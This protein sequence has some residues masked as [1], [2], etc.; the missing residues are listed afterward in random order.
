MR[1]LILV[2]SAAILILLLLLTS[3]TVSQI[4]SN[5]EEESNG[6]LKLTHEQDVKISK[7]I[8]EYNLL[9]NENLT[10]IEENKTLTKENKTLLDKIDVLN[11][12]ATKGNP[13]DYAKRERIFKY[14]NDNR[15]EF[16]NTAL[17]SLFDAGFL[18][19]GDHVGSFFVTDVTLYENEPSG[20]SRICFSG[21]IE[22]RGEFIS[23][24]EASALLFAVSE[25]DFYQIPNYYI[26]E[27]VSLIITNLNK[28]V[29]EKNYDEIQNKIVT[30]NI[31]NLVL[32][33]EEGSDYF[34][35][36]E[37]VSLDIMK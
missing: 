17:F 13:K 20:G 26:A 28:F 19:E 15:E 12:D 6:L 14:L 32:E 34:Y 10:L 1:K 31:T 37:I 29:E 36:C 5:R 35:K 3:C 22:V 33:G 30:L 24:G 8:E 9:K 27:G 16:I 18:H 7:L 21:N 11:F 4:E 25:T 23:G 2:R